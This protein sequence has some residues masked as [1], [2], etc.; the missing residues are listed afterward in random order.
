MAMTAA[1]PPPTALNRDTS[2]GIAVI[3]TRRALMAPAAPPSAV[4]AASAAQPHAV[5]WNASSVATRATV[6][7]TAAAIPEALSRLPRRA[8][9]GERMRCRPSTKVVAAIM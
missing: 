6:A 4:P 5:T 9:A 1:A 3:L 2:C 8:L 7:S